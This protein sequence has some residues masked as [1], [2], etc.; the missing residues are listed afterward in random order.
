M[1][2]GAVLA[3]RYRLTK[4]LGQGGMADMGEH[5]GHP[6]FV[7]EL[8]DGT[9]FTEILAR[10]PGGLPVDRVLE[11]GAAVADA[12]AYAHRRGV[13][14]RDIKPANLMEL[15]EGG[16]KICDFGISR[17][18]DA[19]GRLTATGGMLGTPAYM[20]PEQYEG[21]PA[22]A[23]TDLYAFGC[24]L[25]ALLTGDAPF[26][27]ETVPALMRQHLTVEPAPPSRH[28][29]DVPAELDRLVLWLLA[30]D[31]ADRPGSA[32]DV[33]ERLRAL[34]SG[35]PVPSPEQAPSWSPPPIPS[36]VPAP[37]QADPVPAVPYPGAPPPVHPAPGVQTPQPWPTPV[38]AP[39]V[40]PAV[41]AV[42]AP[43]GPPAAGVGPMAPPVAGMP[44]GGPPPSRR[45][46]R[47][48]FLIGG[49]FVVGGAAV[50]ATA[51]A[52]DLLS[53]GQP[54]NTTLKGHTDNVNAVAFSPDGRTVASGGGDNKVRLWSVAARRM[55]GTFDDAANWI[56]SLAYS[57]DGKYLAAGDGDGTTW[58][59]DLATNRPET[60]EVRVMTVDAVAFSP[61][62]RTLAT[63]HVDNMVRLWKVGSGTK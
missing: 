24:T 40:P 3:D 6:F 12:L 55:I 33:A 5:D 14:H 59:W 23:R 58:L 30:K 20:A 49:L 19:T 28:R 46:G 13:V 8:L 42:P 39:N 4:R 61:D 44:Q 1:E 51:W 38:P 35:R 54:E 57:P 17:S 31:P 56:K 34:A 60:Y 48:S 25:Y 9:D 37:P 21:R 2:S 11:T 32:E 43:A 63:G 47:R 45:T 41:G 26:D 7:M 62:G 16:V 29:P 52:A 27:G 22:D 18:A 10:D 15:A 53:S 50:G 36:P